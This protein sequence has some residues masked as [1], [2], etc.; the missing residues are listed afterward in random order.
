[1]A[2]RRFEMYYYRQAL[3][4]MRL[5]DPDRQIA[6][7][8][9]MGR[10]VAATAR[11]EAAAR[12]W[13]DTDQRSPPDEALASIF[14]APKK[15]RARQSSSLETHRDLITLWFEDGV[16]GTTNH[17]ALKRRYGFTGSYSAVRRFLHT[18]ADATPV[19]VEKCRYSAPWRL[20][21]QV[22]DIRLSETSVRIYQA[23]E[24]KA[25]HPRGPG[26]G[27]RHKIYDHLPPDAV[28][29]KMR[30]PQLCLKV[31]A[32]TGPHC[33]RLVERLFEHRVLDK[34]LAAQGVINM[35]KRYGPAHRYRLPACLLLRQRAI[36]ERAHH[37]GERAGSNR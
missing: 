16:Q 19:Q 7:S 17:D 2:K 35:I 26:P 32:A 36:P 27:Y 21:G 31:A 30:T 15:Q 1:M 4:R 29:Y 33:H 25:V 34:L 11:G 3:V 6:K 10:R 23:H 12:G 20:V 37:S 18:L 9:L 28:A 8:G 14:D 13:L 22:L 24:S 5:G